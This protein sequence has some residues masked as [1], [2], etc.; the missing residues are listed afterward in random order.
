LL[1]DG[2]VLVTGGDRAAWTPS[3]DLASAEI[4]DPK[5]GTFSPTGSMSTVRCFHL[6]TLLADGR[7]LITGGTDG[8]NDLASAEIYNPKT[9]NFSVA[10]SMAVGRAYQTAT[11]LADGRVLVA[12]GG[13]DYTNRQFLASAEIFDP[14]TGTFTPTGSM[15]E[16]RTYHAATLLPDGRVLVTGGYGAVAPLASAETYDPKTG[17]FTPIP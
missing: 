14:K 2:R 12:G 9:G 4:Y 7:V 13:G 8:A 1:A 3:E 6:A 11:R 17:T 10:S 15:A 16:A 5:T